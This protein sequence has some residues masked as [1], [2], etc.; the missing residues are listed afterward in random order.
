MRGVVVAAMAAV[1]AL[2]ACQRERSDEQLPGERPVTV[3]E[4]E[5]R[6]DAVPQE[7]PA[8]ARSQW[9]ATSEQARSVTG[10]LRVSLE[11]RRGGPVVFAF[12][13][14]IT[15][16]A[17]PYNVVP[18]DQRSGA[19]GQSF[20]AVLAGDPRVD[21]YLYRV[22]DENLIPGRRAGLCGEET[23]RHMAVSEFVD[24]SGRWV[25]K[26]AAFRGEARPPSS[27][28]P[29]LCGAFAYTAQ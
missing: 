16:R 17:Q 20:A 14:G 28:D 18:A 6:V 29:E 24:S 27:A 9:R 25:F 1:L 3:V 10:N 7:E 21:A 13:N 4:P 23:T 22:L 11:G 8:V 26:I 15:V 12:A 2:G 19:G 5:T